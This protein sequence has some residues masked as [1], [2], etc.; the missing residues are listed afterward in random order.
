[1]NGGIHI[2]LKADQ[3]GNFFGLPI[4]NTLLSTWVVVI[5]MIVL[6]FFLRRKVALVPGKVHTFV[7]ASFLWILGYMEET[8]ESKELARKFFPLIT[9]LFLFILFAN[10]TELLPGIGSILY[11][12]GTES[13]PLF[14]PAS[15]DL[16]FTL[17]LT[18]ISVVLTEV[19][20]VAFVGILKYGSKFVN[21]KSVLGFFIGIIE[22]IS[23]I[24]RLVSF[25]FRL[26]G[27]MFAG[28]VLILVATFFIP[29]FLPVPVL[30]FEVFIGLIQAA[31]FALLTLF[32][33]KLA[34]TDPHIEME[35][36]GVED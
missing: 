27:N 22:L 15:T 33:I 5:F 10:Y 11:Y 19:L 4:T 1:M 17:A 26:F 2:S 3:L 14:H 36:M 30:L 32:F 8:L 12:K 20:G 35:E 29:Y 28:D 24:A 25:S 7:E 9:T 21:V 16:N 23:E 13:L 18:L 34:I 31:I 6:A